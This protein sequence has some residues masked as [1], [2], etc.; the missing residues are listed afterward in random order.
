MLR[1]VGIRATVKV[2]HSAQRLQLA[3]GGQL[4]IGYLGW[5]GGG[6]FT[7]SPT[8]VRLFMIDEIVD[9]KLGELAEPVLSIVDDAERRRAAAKLFDYYNEQA[10]GYVMHAIPEVFTT[11][12]EVAIRDPHGLRPAR[13]YPHEFYWK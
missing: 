13:I 11:A 12:T 7:V 5:S 9:S 6:N 8:V 2:I 10:Y 4:E 3:R 1:T